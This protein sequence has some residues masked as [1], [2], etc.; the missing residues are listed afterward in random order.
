MTYAELFAAKR[1]Q[2]QGR[3]PSSLQKQHDRDVGSARRSPNLSKV[4]APLRTRSPTADEI[5][6]AKAPYSRSGVA[7]VTAR[8][9][10]DTSQRRSRRQGDKSHH[11]HRE[12]NNN[13]KS[14]HSQLYQRGMRDKVEKERRL[15]ALR[16]KQEVEAMS[17]VTGR[18]QVNQRSR[19]LAESA[20]SLRL[21]VQTQAAG[22]IIPRDDSSDTGSQH[23]AAS[24][25]GRSV[26]AADSPTDV[27][28]LPR[29]EREVR[30]H[31]TFTPTLAVGTQRILE[32][33]EQRQKQKQAPATGGDGA[34]RPTETNTSRISE[35][36]YC[37][38][39]EREERH[40]RLR[41][42]AAI[43]ARAK[44]PFA[45][46]TSVTAKKNAQVEASRRQHAQQHGGHHHR[47][48][49]DRSLS[50]TG[51]GW[52]GVS[53]ID[54]ASSMT[55]APY[56]DVGAGG[57]GGEPD[58]VDS[59]T[60]NQPQTPALSKLDASASHGTGQRGLP[61]QDRF[62][63]LYD[64][65]RSQAARRREASQR[66]HEL[67]VVDPETGRPLFTPQ[68]GRE[69]SFDRRARMSGLDIG[70]Y[71][72]AGRHL[73]ADLQQADEH[74]AE[75]EDH[76]VDEADRARRNALAVRDK[77]AAAA[78]ASGS[79]NRR[80]RPTVHLATAKE[81]LATSSLFHALA[82]AEAEAQGRHEHDA[83]SIQDFA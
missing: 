38:A 63:A 4:A 18:P 33:H 17:E 28:R 9:S 50:P 53:R 13:N 56:D 35:R 16:R 74:L 1:H 67:S 11:S 79:R 65:A 81:Q 48:G 69:P 25:S 5:L 80:S 61:T 12:D 2:R 40:R 15:E 68:V 49:D 72:Y 59:P 71:L 21:R 23:G 54:G 64:Q 45:P 8:S 19:Q 27:S 24:G 41:E 47:G 77:S 20:P 52:G 83:S 43:E 66:A 29:E 58:G 6:A 60:G 62:T 46:D 51:I 30:E 76:A 73:K 57:S 34:S 36:L 7:P 32:R 39:A 82:E 78:A 70:S 26:V 10:F 31:C 37:E 55:H 14:F 75:A 44:L 42:N 22:G 3:R